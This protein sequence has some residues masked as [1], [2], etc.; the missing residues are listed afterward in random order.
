[1]DVI[2]FKSRNGLTFRRDKTE[3]N[4]TL[5]YFVSSSDWKP[6]QSKVIT[7]IVEL[8]W[9]V[10]RRALEAFPSEAGWQ[11]STTDTA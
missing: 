8:D 11:Y 4:S 2:K 7:L 6:S 5:E 9:Q 1:M 3:H 10:W